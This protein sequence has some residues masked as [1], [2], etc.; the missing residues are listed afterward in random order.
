ME[1]MSEVRGSV[2]SIEFPDATI[3]YTQDARGLKPQQTNKKQKVRAH[4]HILISKMPHMMQ[5]T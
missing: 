1:S 4:G 3:F 5:G 2:C